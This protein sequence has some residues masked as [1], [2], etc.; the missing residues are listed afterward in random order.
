MYKIAK[1]VF[2]K[3]VTPLHAGSGQDLGIV[4]LP[5][6]RER[7]TKFP[8]IE[9]SSIKG[10]IRE[11]F[12]DLEKENKLEKYGVDDI[13]SLVFGP[14][15]GDVH[16]SSIAFTD[17]RILLFPVKSVKGVYAY[18]TSPKVLERFKKDL[19]ISKTLG[20]IKEYFFDEEKKLKELTVSNREKLCISE[21]VILEEYAFEV[22]FSEDTKEFA[23]WLSKLLNIEEIK[24]KLVILPDDVFG[25]FVNL[26]T[27]VITRIKI[28]PETG[29]VEGSALFTEEY[30]PSETVMYFLCMASPIFLKK[31]KKEKILKELMKNEKFSEEKFVMNFFEKNLPKIIQIGGNA[32]IGKGISELKVWKT[33]GDK[34]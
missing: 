7:H 8:K 19:E 3:V 18:I 10:C 20:G 21:K 11:S 32:T 22:E 2:L 15:S 5:I 30:L 12:E 13:I 25:D 31:D 9:S 33:E 23:E 34:Q 1:P 24:D 14:E 17:A 16:A 6:Q 4:D 28:N 26:S 29:T 27:E